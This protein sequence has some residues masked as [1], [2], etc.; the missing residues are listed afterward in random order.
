M[1]LLSSHPQIVHYLQ[2]PGAHNV[3]FPIR[4]AVAAHTLLTWTG[5]VVCTYC[6]P[7]RTATAPA[8]GLTTTGMVLDVGKLSTSDTYSDTLFAFIGRAILLFWRCG[9]VGRRWLGAG[10][11]LCGFL[12]GEV[13]LGFLLRCGG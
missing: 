3:V 10:C 8:L 13:G 9:S 1:V 12:R 6:T 2:A 7:A 4:R 5:M 11:S